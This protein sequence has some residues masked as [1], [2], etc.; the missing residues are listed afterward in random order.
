[1]KPRTINDYTVLDS[2]KLR[3]DKIQDL[4][5]TEIE[6]LEKL[7]KC[8]DDKEKSE[9]YTV[10]KVALLRHLEK[11]N[12]LIPSEKKMPESALYTFINNIDDVKPN[13]VRQLRADMEKDEKG[14]NKKRGGL[15][16][17][18]STTLKQLTVTTNRVINILEAPQ[19][20]QQIYEAQINFLLLKRNFYATTNS[21]YTHYHDKYQSLLK[22]LT[23]AEIIKSSA[24]SKGQISEYSFNEDLTSIS[25]SAIQTLQREI[26]NDKKGIN[27]R[28]SGFF[29]NSSSVND[30]EIANKEV[31]QILQTV[32]ISHS[33][34]RRPSES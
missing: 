32:D 21:K 34:T 16:F 19:K 27:K 13:V 1:M 14:I 26:V 17:F 4:Y 2:R 25:I 12:I 10:K 31:I 23:K 28:S 8:S 11:A 5:K 30:L 18:H 7:A 33:L 29:F 3:L 24:D 22:H 15:P 20:I 6:N 9:H